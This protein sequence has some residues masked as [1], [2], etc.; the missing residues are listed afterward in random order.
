MPGVGGAGAA[1]G[2]GVLSGRAAY[3]VEELL[4]YCGIDAA[5]F[6]EENRT[7]LFI[8]EDLAVFVV[9]EEDLVHVAAPLGAPARGEAFC[10]ALLEQNFSNLTCSG[11]GYSVD[12]GSGELVMSMTLRAA[13]LDTAGLVRAFEGFVRYAEDWMMSLLAGDGAV[14]A[15]GED[16]GPSLPDRDVSAA[17]PGDVDVAFMKV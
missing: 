17:G 10:L 9:A 15:R 6:R 1:Q 12:P 7:L 11:Y 5:G 8:G 16:G 3:L 4:A 13:A 14:P 2:D